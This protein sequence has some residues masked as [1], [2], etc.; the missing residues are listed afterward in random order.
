MMTVT[1]EV[2]VLKNYINGEWVETSGTDMLEIR[3]PANTDELVVKVQQS[4]ADDAQ[5]AIEAAEKA[6]PEW[7]KTPSPARGEYLFKIAALME[8]EADEI[9]RIIVQEEGKTYADAFKEVNYAAGIVKF[10]AGEGRRMTGRIVESDM[11]GVQIEL[12][13]EALGVVLVVTPWNFPLSIPAWKIAPAILSGNTVVLKASSETPLTAQKFI[14]IV[15]RAGVPAGVV[16]QLVGPGR[17]VTDMINHPA[18]KA[19][20]FTGSNRV[21][22]LIYKEAAKD[23]KRV[24]LEMGGKNPLLVMED[25][26]VDAAVQLAVA[27]GYGQTGQAC[28]ATSRVLVHKDIRQEFTDKLVE[29]SKKIKIGNGM[30]E[31]VTMGPQVSD[32]ERQSTLDLI[33]KAIAEGGE[34]LTGGGIPVFEG[35]DKGFFVEPTVIGGVKT[36]MTIAQEEV[37]GPVISIIEIESIDEAIEVANDVA[38]GLSAAICTRNLTYMN[39]ALNEIQAGIVKVNMTTTGTFF[40]APFGGYKQSSTGTYKELGSEAVEFYCQNKTRYI[41]SN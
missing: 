12:H 7:S 27:G 28:T 26:D 36:D 35:S 38:F 2:K 40:Q 24:L 21:G 16:N 20:T 41:N 23:M 22:N 14:E 4:N 32:G 19:I 37:F 33:E 29:A 34:I 9:A 39:R 1:S 11:P 17:L 6:F 25:A 15:E 18:V 3:N 30:D 13:K 10:Y 5:A 31:G 8:A